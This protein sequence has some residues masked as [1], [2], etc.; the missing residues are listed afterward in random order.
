MEYRDA[1]IYA[2]LLVLFDQLSAKLHAVRESLPYS[3]EEARHVGL[4][5]MQLVLAGYATGFS[6]MIFDRTESQIIRSFGHSNLSPTE[7]SGTVEDAWRLGLLT[8]FHFKVDSLFQ[9][10]LRVLGR[11]DQRRRSFSY[12]TNTLLEAVSIPAKD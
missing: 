9:N 3:N 1:K 2:H 6:S 5:G 7:A 10:L 11:Y 12:L 8:L 4:R